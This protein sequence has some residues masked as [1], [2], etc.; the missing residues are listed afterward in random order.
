MMSVYVQQSPNLICIINSDCSNVSWRW[1]EFGLTFLSQVQRTYA[2][3]DATNK[4][5]KFL[6]H[7]RGKSF[8]FIFCECFTAWGRACIYIK[9][10]Y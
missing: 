10:I 5:S 4:M 7:V 8:N 1:L 2:A 3:N 6:V 9:C